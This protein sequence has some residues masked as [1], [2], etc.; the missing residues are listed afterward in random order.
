MADE[1]EN[2]NSKRILAELAVPI[3][4]DLL[5]PGVK[6]V[7]RALTVIGKTTNLALAPLRGVV[8]S[9][10]IF[11]SWLVSKVEPH[12]SNVDS[13]QIGSPD[14]AIAGP[15]VNAMKY[16]AEDT[17][18]T[19]MYAKLLA[20]SMIKDERRNAHP[21][22]VHLIGQLTQ[23]EAKLIAHIFKSGPAA[24]VLPMLIDHKKSRSKTYRSRL[25]CLPFD[26]DCTFPEDF[27]LYLDNL[28]RLQICEY[29]DDSF[30]VE[31]KDEYDRV[32]ELPSMVDVLKEGESEG[33]DLAVAK[34]HVTL[35]VFGARF[36]KACIA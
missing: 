18:L 19:E 36:A 33:Y 10:E 14:L 3:Y 4:N 34:G 13:S 17:T 15:L 30:M 21:G 35:S 26:A 12:F 23:D 27:Q 2:S 5:Q 1:S 31:K 8:W 22:F 11:E 6:E 24:I 16:V 28:R 29:D 25:S 9:Y 32:F 7:G 20:T